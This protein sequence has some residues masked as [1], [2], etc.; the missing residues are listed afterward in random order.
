MIAIAQ[1]SACVFTCGAYIAQN[2]WCIS[3]YCGKTCVTGTGW[4]PAGMWMYNITN[5]RRQAFID[6]KAFNIF[7]RRHIPEN[8]RHCKQGNIIS[9]IKK[10]ISHTTPRGGASP[11]SLT[12]DSCVRHNKLTKAARPPAFLISLLFSSFCL[13]YDRFLKAPHAFLKLFFKN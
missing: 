8:T 7:T 12:S 2:A 3:K 10:N 5:D 9:N 4:V 6:D 13:P 1:L 11:S